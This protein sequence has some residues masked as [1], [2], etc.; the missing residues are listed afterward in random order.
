V[1][2]QVN[3]VCAECGDRIGVYERFWMQQADGTVASPRDSDVIEN[4]ARLIHDD[5]LRGA[6]AA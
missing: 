5:C 4:G 1:N 6:S 2:G 3:L